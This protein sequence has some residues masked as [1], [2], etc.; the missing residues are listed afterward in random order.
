MLLMSFL[1]TNPGVLILTGFTGMHHLIDDTSAKIPA[2]ITQNSRNGSTG[3][4]SR[5]L[6]LM[7]I[8]N[9]RLLF[10]ELYLQFF[11]NLKLLPIHLFLFILMLHPTLS[12]S[13]ENVLNRCAFNLNFE[14][15]E[16][17]PPLSLPIVVRLIDAVKRWKH[18]CLLQAGFQREG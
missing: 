9:I 12:R 15:T 13:H 18:W 8:V 5:A 6:I 3:P 2:R 16:F 1:E 17:I 10:S 7:K 4:Q 11:H 14:C